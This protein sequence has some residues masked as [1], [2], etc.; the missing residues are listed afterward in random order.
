LLDENPRHGYDLM[1]S[2]EDMF[3]GLYAPSAGT[4]Y[5]RLAALEDDGLIEHDVE[6]GRK[7]Y[8]LTDAGR[9]ELTRRRMETDEVAE[10]VRESARN[11]ANEIRHEV[12]ATVRD[13]RR[14]IKD[15]AQE[16]RRQERRATRDAQA[17]GRELHRAM[18][19]LRGD[20]ES[21]KVDVMAAA[22]Q[23]ELDRKAL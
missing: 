9:E 19:S 18:R 17:A 5:P 15:A 11:L 6:A 14:E 10:Q 21:F 13:L 7:V 22:R 23:H 1:R 3:L 2:L 20:L 8:R 4:I 12:R 16:A